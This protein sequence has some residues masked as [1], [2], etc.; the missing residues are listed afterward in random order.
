MSS[1]TTVQLSDE[2]FSYS[3]SEDLS[4]YIG[5]VYS[6]NIASSGATLSLLSQFGTT[7]DKTSGYILI[8]KVSDWINRYNTVYKGICGSI[9]V[10]NPNPTAI[11]IQCD[12][13]GA[14]PSTCY[15]GAT[16]TLAT[17]WWSVHNFLQYGGKCIIAG[18][19]DIWNENSNQLLDK[20]K[21]PGIDL[22]FALDHTEKQANLVKDTI[23]GRNYDCF[24]VVGVSGTVSGYGEPVNG[25][26]GQT[27]GEITPRGLSLGQYG[28]AVYGYK[29]HFGLNQNLE[30]VLSPLIADAAGCIIRTDRD[31][32]PWFSPAG[33]NRG[34]L[35]N[36]ISLD[37]SPSEASQ[38]HLASKNVNFFVTVSGQGSFLFSD[39]TLLQ[40]TESPYK[41]VNV[42]RLLIF[43]IKNIAPIA[44]RYLFEFNNDL[45]RLSFT[46]NIEPILEEARSSGGLTDY[47]IVCDESNNTPDII[48]QNNFVADITITSSVPVMTI[49][50]RFTNLNT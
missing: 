2:N 25:V 44:K 46:N 31:Y 42:S 30:T 4:N 16:G 12:A 7:A 39:K 13:T 19:S 3:F 50:L 49:N 17:H 9:S 18:D 21:F 15:N 35:L 29:V 26:G 45:T 34:K 23:I 47:T 41:F 14:S 40:N 24:G 43:L 6:H 8:D 48:A 20:S 38:V 1:I 10:K 37:K 36:S 5:A 11:G 28:M 33:F 32:Y 27:A 22:V